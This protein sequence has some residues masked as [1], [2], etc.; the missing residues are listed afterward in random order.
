MSPTQKLGVGWER[1]QQMLLRNKNAKLTAGQ[2][3]SDSVGMSL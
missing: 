2:A 3:L 1:K